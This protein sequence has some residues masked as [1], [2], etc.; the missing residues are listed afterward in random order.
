MAG[1]VGPEIP[2]V[3]DGLVFYVDAALTY[4][5]GDTTW[6]D[7][8][9]GKTGTLTNGP[10]YS[11][12]GRGSIVLDGTNDQIVWN[13]HD[14]LD[15]DSQNYSVSVWC[16]YNGPSLTTTSVIEPIISKGTYNGSGGEWEIIIRGGSINGFYFRQRNPSSIDNVDC[17]TDIRSTIEGGD[18]HMYT[19]VINFSSGEIRTYFDTTEIGSKTGGLALSS[20][21]STGNLLIGQYVTWWGAINV[22][23]VSF[24]K[25]KVLSSTE[26]T[27]NYN[28][29]KGRFGL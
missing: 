27:Q 2:G 16:K 22:A 3:T 18:F 13:D 19:A 23:L 26:I 10:T 9:K 28:A 4:T 5:S 20:L 17:A 8:I 6:Y 15:P 25:G 24:Y 12:D 14:D 1:F 7:K 11:A 29:L 21:S